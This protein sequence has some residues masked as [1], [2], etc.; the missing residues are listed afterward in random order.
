[1]EEK[2][3]LNEF[4]QYVDEII[5][6]RGLEYF[7][8]E[9]VNEPEEISPGVFSAIVEGSEDYT[10]KV[11]IKK[12]KIVYFN[13]DCPYDWGPIC[14]HIA[15]VFYC[16]R[17]Q[18]F[19]TDNA[20]PTVNTSGKKKTAIRK[21]FTTQINLLLDK[22]STKEL[23]QFVREKA[24]QNPGFRNIFLSAF[25]YLNADESKELYVRQIKSI[26]KKYTSRDGFIDWSAARQVDSEVSELLNSAQIQ[27]EKKN[28]QSV[29][30]IC[31]AVL[32]QMT[33]ALQYADDS[34][35]DIGGNIE[36][37]LG[38]LYEMTQEK[39]YEEIRRL[40]FDY[41]VSAFKSTIY[42]GWDWHLGMLEIASEISQTDEEIQLVLDII[43][44]NQVSEYENRV[45]Q[46]L[47]YDLLKKSGGEKEAESYLEKNISNP[48]LRREALKKAIQG[49]KYE[50]AISIAND[51]INQDKKDKPGLVME[52]Y[53]WLLKIAQIQ[54][55]KEKVIE[56]AKLLLIDNFR[57]EHDYYQILKKNVQPEKWN[58][59]V[60]E[61]VKKIID[62]KGWLD[63][64]L[65]AEIYIKEEWW[66]RLLELIRKNPTL[67]MIENYERYLS[68]TY[69]GELVQL[70]SDAIIEFLKNNVKRKH[71]QIVCKYLRR[72]IKLGAREKS[73]EL[74]ARF[75]AEYPH[76]RALLE[77][78]NRV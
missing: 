28:Y 56:Y 65:T 35:G 9:Q 7:E 26:L 63:F 67:H 45:I 64:H 68:K 48:L 36:I 5:L 73:V 71:Y 54:K 27:Y 43:G 3:P 31:T 17:E 57:H 47:E 50:K 32:E 30:F 15:A 40:L 66:D 10:V 37:A 76:R 75:K 18:I 52:W 34:N 53:D 72:I 4:E 1:M 8:N 11:S 70:Y 77:E 78:L 39:L 22:I 29:I 19:K 21:D 61:M 74:I 16:L 55:D 69:P 46:S 24:A 6:E 60:E 2:I 25:S 33:E 42:S 20:S 49:K 62:K 59:F 23:K 58:S 14:K 13:C 44:K 41:C 38:M 12:G 51:G